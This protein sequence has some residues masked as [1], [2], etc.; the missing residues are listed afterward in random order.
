[1]EFLGYG[2]CH[3]RAGTVFFGS[4][5]YMPVCSRCTGIYIGFIF[6]LLMILLADRRLKIVLPGKK[7]IAALI[8]FFAL[9]VLDVFLS[10]IRVLPA[11]ADNIIRFLTGYFTGMFLPLLL[12]PLKNSLVFKKQVITAGTYLSGRKRF[13]TNVLHGPERGTGSL[14][15]WRPLY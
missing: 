4:D 1:M 8:G 7:I 10:A 3:Q 15:E 12:L 5:I 2:A 11:G 6:T 9:M 13:T 14:C